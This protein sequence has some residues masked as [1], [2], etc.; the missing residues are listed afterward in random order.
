MLR[1]R[2]FETHNRYPDVNI[3]VAGIC[4]ETDQK[5]KQLAQDLNITEPSFPVGGPAYF[6]DTFSKLS[7]EH[8][9]NE[10]IFYNL[11]QQTDDRK[12]GVQVL[13]EVFDLQAKSALETQAV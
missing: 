2:F 4:H 12:A 7:E 8:G 9:V 13:G 10:I 11:A 5:A 3:C 1:D 6:Q